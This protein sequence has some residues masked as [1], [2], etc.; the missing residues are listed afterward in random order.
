[1]SPSKHL[2]G[3]ALLAVLLATSTWACSQVAVVVGQNSAVTSMT[4]DQVRDIIEAAP[5]AT[6][7]MYAGSG[8]AG[9]LRILASQ[10]A[11]VDPNYEA[12]DRYS[13]FSKVEDEDDE[14]DEDDDDVDDDDDDDD[15]DDDN[16]D[17]DADERRP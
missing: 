9:V 8:R 10:G 14:D 12:H 15:G 3:A 7:A 2:R 17:D 6:V 4:A 13:R 5:G 1:M 16:D 11:M